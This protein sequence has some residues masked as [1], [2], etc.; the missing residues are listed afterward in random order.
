MV[1]SVSSQLVGKVMIAS[2]IGAYVKPVAQS[3]RGS[4]G[5]VVHNEM[6]VNEDLSPLTDTLSPCLTY[7]TYLSP[8]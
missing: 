8:L 6:A 3:T 7:V 1:N 5:F 2:V 4:W